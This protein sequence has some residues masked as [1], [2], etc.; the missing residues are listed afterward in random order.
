[1]KMCSLPQPM[2]SKFVYEFDR[3]FIFFFSKS[4]KQG[5]W[6]PVFR[7]PLKHFSVLSTPSSILHYSCS[8]SIFNVQIINLYILSVGLSLQGISAA[9]KTA[10]PDVPSSPAIWLIFIF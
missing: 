7:A 4:E 3:I 9:G 8:A 10:L 5:F 2:T 6:D 1:M